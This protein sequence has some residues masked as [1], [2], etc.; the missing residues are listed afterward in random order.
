MAPHDLA[1]F[2]DR[3]LSELYRGDLR[4]ALRMADWLGR[5][6]VAFGPPEPARPPDAVSPL[7]G[8]VAVR[9]YASGGAVLGYPEPP[10]RGCFRVP[11]E[12]APSALPD[13]PPALRLVHGRRPAA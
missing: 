12:D 2:H 3:C 10:G 13:R 6:W 4:A 5:R 8:A 9:W 11:A 7:A 1:R